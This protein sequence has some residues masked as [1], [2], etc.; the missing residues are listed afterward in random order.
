ME[1]VS[2]SPTQTL[3][4]TP[5]IHTRGRRVARKQQKR[6]PEAISIQR[7]AELLDVHPMTIRRWIKRGIIKAYRVGPQIVRIPRSE[8]VR[9]RSIRLH[10]EY[11]RGG[12]TI[13]PV[14]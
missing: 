1:W 9:L 3:T 8:I 13:Y 14:V 11:H 7:V 2:S 6:L 10:Y 5:T 12:I 4:W